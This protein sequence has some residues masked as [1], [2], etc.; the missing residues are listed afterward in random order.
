MSTLRVASDVDWNLNL[1]FIFM[2]KTILVTGGAGYIGS[3]AVRRLLDKGYHVVVFDNL[4]RGFRKSIEI[5]QQKYTS[6]KVDLCVGDLRNKEDLHKLFN[7][8]YKFDAV[9][10]FAALCVLSES[11][12][13][14]IKYFENNV[15]GSLNLFGAMV[16]NNIKRVVYSSTCAVYG[17]SKYLPIDENHPINPLTPYAESKLQV[18]KM[19]M[20]FDKAY[21]LKSVIF[22]YFNVSGA[23]SDGLIGDSK[24]PSLLLIQ[25]A[26]RGALGIETFKITC[27]KVETRD[28]SP[29]RDFVNIEDL[30]E[31]HLKALDYLF[32]GGKS[33]VFNLGTGMG[34]SVKEIIDEVRRILK[35]DFKVNKAK[36]RK[37]EAAEI[38]ADILKARKIL[39][40]TPKSSLGDTIRSL[41]KWYMNKPYGYVK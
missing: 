6:E 23:S 12:F 15:K 8:N 20:W 14:P 32:K 41:A 11:L 2:N 21:G 22:R 13:D 9:M 40:W 37:G 26:V 5:L 25:N 24:K 38:F 39:K 35:V 17:E 3:H 16:E 18:E 30:V 4:Q 28:G 36:P 31:A 19:L 10:H 33:D 27:S 7:K 29:I 1:T 34:Y